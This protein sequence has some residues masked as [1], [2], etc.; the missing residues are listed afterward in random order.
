[1]TKDRRI[2]GG[3]GGAA[4]VPEVHRGALRNLRF[5]ALHITVEQLPEQ[6]CLRVTVLSRGNAHSVLQR[7]EGMV[8]EVK[9]E[10]MPRLQFFAALPVPQLDDEA[11]LAAGELHLIP[12]G[13]VREAQR[14]AALVRRSAAE[15]VRQ[16]KQRLERPR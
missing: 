9:R 13:V 2:A 11:T 5:G 6:P 3:V 12:V 1:M 8:S 15:V 10:C 7:L 4:A 16:A 14:K